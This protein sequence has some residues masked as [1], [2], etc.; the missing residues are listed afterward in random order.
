M[1]NIVLFG[2]GNQVTYCID[3]IE[4]ENKYKII[5]IID[6]IAPIDTEIMGYKVIGRQEEISELVARYK[7]EAGIITIGDNWSR[8][9]VYDDVCKYYPNFEFVSTI[10]P[11]IPIGKNTI[12][13][14]GTLMM[15]G[16]IVNTNVKIGKFC[17]FATG[18]QIEHDCVVDDFAS[19]SA[20]TVT[21]G[22]V[23][24]GKFS[25]L[26]LGVVVMDRLTIGE[27][28]VIGARSLVTKDIPDNV[29]A[30]GTPAKIIRQREKGEKFLK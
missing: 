20:G 18:A 10:H 8:K 7:I 26:T 1:K 15:A 23:K 19:I 17:F 6:S 21:G 25:A 27:N 5:G 2:G 13:G 22:K 9:K 29:L 12:I 28:S 3:I 24:I 30:Y 11:S 4:K 14:E 16:C